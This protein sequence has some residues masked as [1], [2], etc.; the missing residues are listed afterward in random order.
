MVGTVKSRVINKQCARTIELVRMVLAFMV[1]SRIQ[2]RDE[3]RVYWN[4]E[5]GVKAYIFFNVLF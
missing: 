3:K 1:T 2:A 5:R 4:K